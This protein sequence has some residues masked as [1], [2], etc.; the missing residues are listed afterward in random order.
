MEK[1]TSSLRNYY[2]GAKCSKGRKNLSI[3]CQ[4]RRTRIRCFHSNRNVSLKCPGEQ[5]NFSE[6]PFRTKEGLVYALALGPWHQLNENARLLLRKDSVPIQL[7]FVQE[8]G[9]CC[10]LTTFSLNCAYAFTSP[11]SGG[12]TKRAECWRGPQTASH[13][14][15]L[16]ESR[17]P[18]IHE[19]WS[20]RR[21]P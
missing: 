18:K 13:P 19:S 2:F 7:K 1:N 15:W 3:A 5:C 10:R 4:H 14:R 9:R 8:R 6:G 21:C 12:R 11:R 17:M 16:P 20:L